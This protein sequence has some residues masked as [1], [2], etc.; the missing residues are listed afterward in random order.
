MPQCHKCTHFFNRIKGT[1]RTDPRRWCCD[2][3]ISALPPKVE[4]ANCKECKNS[5][6][7]TT[8]K[9]EMCKEC[10]LSEVTC[11]KCADVYKKYEISGHGDLRI[12][13]HQCSHDV[14]G[15][16]DCCEDVTRSQKD[17]HVCQD[18][19]VTSK[20]VMRAFHRQLSDLEFRV[21]TLEEELEETIKKLDSA[22]R[23]LLRRK[24]KTEK[25]WNYEEDVEDSD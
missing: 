15:C 14:L 22:H 5:V 11:D 13:W 23:K 8:I 24:M 21:E 20:M 2:S 25:S 16:P 17:S 7:K 10:L 3:C 4:M 12:T 6:D 9:H 18:L 19:P 1:P